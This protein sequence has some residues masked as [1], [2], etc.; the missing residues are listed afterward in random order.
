MVF[1]PSF[2][3]WGWATQ[4][5]ANSEA[6]SPSR[7]SSGPRSRFKPPASESS[8]S[9]SAL[10]Q[11]LDR[12]DRPRRPAAGRSSIRSDA[13]AW[14]SPEA[15][16]RCAR[17]NIRRCCACCASPSRSVPTASR[18]SRSPASRRCNEPFVDVLIEVTWPSGRLQREYPILLDPPGFAARP[19][20]RPPAAA[21]AA[22]AQ[23]AAARLRPRRRSR[24]RPPIAAPS[25]GALGEIRDGGRGCGRPV[26]RAGQGHLRPGREGREP[27]ARSPGR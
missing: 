25:G 6:E 9:N 14:R 21:A 20:P 3:G 12:R 18:T 7:C 5:W 8:R 13:R 11:V 22:P 1:Q 23:A 17:S 4:C 2:P 16:P 26:G 24:R 19:A 15:Y 10:G 27:A